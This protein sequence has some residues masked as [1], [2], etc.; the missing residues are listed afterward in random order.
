MRCRICNR[1]VATIASTAKEPFVAQVQ[2]FECLCYAHAKA[3]VGSQRIVL[4]A[5]LT[6]R[7]VEELD[8]IEHGHEVDVA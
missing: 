6:D 7:G 2:Y 8:R 4:D 5:P 1:P 3:V